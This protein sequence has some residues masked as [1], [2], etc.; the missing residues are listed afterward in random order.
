MGGCV[1]RFGLVGAEVEVG[2]TRYRVRKLLGR[3]KG[4]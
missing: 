3:G 1:D 2:G 4:G